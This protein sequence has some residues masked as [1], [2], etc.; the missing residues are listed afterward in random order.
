[1]LISDQPFQLSARRPLRQGN[2]R[3]GH[4]HPQGGPG[5]LAA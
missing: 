3:S 2:D 5:D 1:M 4:P